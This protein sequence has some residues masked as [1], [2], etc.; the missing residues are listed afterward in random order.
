MKSGW[1][2]THN[3][4]FGGE[5][6]RDS[7]SQPFVPFASSCDCISVMNNGVPTYVYLYSG[8]NVSKDG[9]S[10]VGLYVN[11]TWQVS[12]RLTVNLG[13][14]FDR[15]NVFLPSQTGPD[16]SQYA[17]SNSAVTWNNTGPRV[18]VT[19]DVTGHANTVIRA[20]F[21]QFYLYP[22][23]DFAANFNPN[24]A[25]WYKEYA[26]TDTNKNGVYDPGESGRLVASSGGTATTTLD[27]HIKNTYTLQSTTY[28]E[29]QV[30]SNFSLRTGFVWNGRR[31]VRGSVNANRPFGAYSVPVS[32]TDPGPDGKV[33]T[34]DDGPAL[35]AHNLASAYLSLPVLNLTTN[36]PENSKYYTWEITAVK[37]DSG[38]RWSLLASFAKTWSDETPLGTG[39]AFTPNQLISTQ[40]GLNVYNNWQ[41]K[42]NS[43]VRLPWGILLTPIMRVQ[44][45]T[46]YARTFVS[47]LNYGSATILSQAYDANRTANIAL[48]DI[49]SEKQFHIR[50]RFK[51]TGFV[52]VYNIFNTNA[53]QA[54]STSSGSSYLRPT[55]ITPPRVARLGVKFQF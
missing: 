40:G 48:F 4:K 1:W 12:H 3:F 28:L 46:P 2:G 31:E 34:L 54:I 8:A 18:G 29:R 43:T 33:G 37:R 20:S 41:G 5:Y 6:M 9:L 44:S 53:E 55:A 36:L 45:G 19:Y 10:T 51:L 35:T 42:V 47:T 17:A 38:D 39:S 30:G 24:P 14:R 25:G 23:A 49:R 21:G 7:L 22:G 27:P 26:W 11:D 52:D 13:V 15:Q 32:I 50:E 16:G